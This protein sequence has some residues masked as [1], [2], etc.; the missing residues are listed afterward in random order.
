VE[1]LQRCGA[2]RLEDL[3]RVRVLDVDRITVAGDAFT[4]DQKLSGH[5]P[6][7]YRHLTLPP[8]QR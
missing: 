4:T 5:R 7:S 8:V 1:L 3:L 2:D 6:R